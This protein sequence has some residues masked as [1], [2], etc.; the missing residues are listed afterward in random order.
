MKSFKHILVYVDTLNHNAPIALNKAIQIASGN[1]GA[2]TLIDV[3]EEV[4]WFMNAISHKAQ[5]ILNSTEDMRREKMEELA[6]EARNFDIPVKTLLVHGK[7]FEEITREVIRDNYDLVMKTA[8]PASEA[9]NRQGLYGSTAIRL[10]R[11]CPCP[12]WIITPDAPENFSKIT[13]AIDPAPK[14]ESHNNL[15]KKLMETAISV[16]C[17]E[18][19][20]LTILHAWSLFAESLFSARMSP[21]ELREHIETVEKQVMEMVNTF[22]IPFKDFLPEGHV[23]LVRGEPGFAIPE[24]VNQSNTELLIIGTNGR[25]GIPHFFSGHI[26]EMVLNEIKCSVLVIKPDDFV[27]PIHP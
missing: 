18:K 19:G 26:A 10:V 12:V 27:S 9:A 6:E 21:Q 1:H 22:L 3:V 14:D 4:P 5:S 15:S 2:I 23:E 25:S 7:P 17:P 11:K 13:V 24:Y 16:T 8:N 20:V